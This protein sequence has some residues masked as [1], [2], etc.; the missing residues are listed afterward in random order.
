MA[1]MATKSF[2]CFIMGKMVSPPFLSH[3]D[4]IFTKLAGIQDSR[5]AGL[6][7]SLQC[8]APLNTGKILID[9]NGK[10]MSSH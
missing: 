10:M 2:H 5:K 6:D 9:Y 1:V 4:Q 7:Q 3:F 8:Y